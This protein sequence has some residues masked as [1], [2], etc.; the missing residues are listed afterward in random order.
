MPHEQALPIEHVVAPFTYVSVPVWPP[1]LT[2]TFLRG[3]LVKSLILTAIIPLFLSKSML[4]I[5]VPVPNIL[6][7]VGMPVDSKSLRHII[8]KLTFVKVT[9]CMV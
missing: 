4:L 9:T 1:V 6:A 5:L 3:V 8:N 7:S 2:L